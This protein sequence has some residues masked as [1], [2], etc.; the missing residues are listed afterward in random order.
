MLN[1]AYVLRSSTPHL[2]PHLD[3][4]DSTRRDPTGNRIVC[5]LPSRHPHTPREPTRLA[6]G[7]CGSLSLPPAV[8]CYSPETLDAA[9]DAVTRA[10]VREQVCVD[11]D[12]S[13]VELPLLF[14]WYARDLGAAG[15]AERAAHSFTPMELGLA[16]ARP[17]SLESAIADA[18]AARADAPAGAPHA[19]CVRFAALYMDDAARRKE[20]LALA[21]S[22][23]LHV[24]FAPF[25]FRCR[26]LALLEDADLGLAHL[27]AQPQDVD[28]EEYRPWQ[29]G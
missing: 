26:T 4:R 13:T 12:G 22:D 8:P 6:C 3:R 23:K 19:D 17:R 1:R 15:A 28:G 21:D 25:S 27:T 10:L 11:A 20:L 7:S 29:R 24:R 5:D 9:L 16:Q 14:S 18:H 2:E